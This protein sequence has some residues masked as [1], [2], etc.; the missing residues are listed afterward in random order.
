MPQIT[1]TTNPVTVG[2]TGIIS[3]TFIIH[4]VDWSMTFSSHVEDQQ[5]STASHAGGTSIVTSSHIAHTSPTSTIHVGDSSPTSVSHVGDLSPATASHVGGIH[6][7]EK[8]RCVI[9]KARFLCRSCEGSHLT[10]LCPTTTRIPEACFSLEGPS[11]SDSPMVS[12][13]SVPSLVH[14]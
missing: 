12:P 1:T 3:P 7:I 8:P 14:T 6:T 13:H 4:V 10:C 5:P 9:H 11:S 2:H